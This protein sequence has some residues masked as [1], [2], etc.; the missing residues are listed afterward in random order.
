MTNNSHHSGGLRSRKVDFKKGLNVHRQDDLPDL[1]E[2]NS[3]NRSNAVIATGVEKEE[4]EEHH[5]QVALNSKHT[6]ESHASVYIPTPDATKV[7]LKN[8]QQFYK[9]EFV[10]PKTLIKF[11]SQIEDCIGAHY[12]LDERDMAW[13]EEEIW[14]NETT[15]SRKLNEDGFE[16][17]MSH[18]EML[19]KEKLTG[20]CP[21]LEEFY[22]LVQVHSPQTL[23][24]KQ[25]FDK[26]FSWWK[27]RRYV[28]RKGKAITPSLVHEE[29]LGVENDPYVCFRRREIKT[30]RKTRRCDTLSLEKLKKLRDEMKKAR[31][32]LELVCTREKLRKELLKSEIDV[33]EARI[34]V[35]K[36]KKILGIATTSQDVENSPEKA[37]RKYNKSNSHAKIKISL[38]KGDSAIWDKGSSLE[39]QPI[40]SRIK[41]R[42]LTDE[43]DGVGDFTEYPYIPQLPAHPGHNFWSLQSA[44]SH[45]DSPDDLTKIQQPL[46]GRQNLL[47]RRRV[48]RGGRIIFDRHYNR[49]ELLNLVRCE[50]YI[51]KNT[52][53]EE[54]DTFETK[55]IKKWK[56]D[57]SDEDIEDKIVEL[58]EQ[59]RFTMYR[60]FNLAPGNEAECRSL[61]NK[62]SFPEQTTIIPY[63]HEKRAQLYNQSINQSFH[64]SSL[65]NNNITKANK[66]AL[67]LSRPSLT[68]LENKD[69]DSKSDEKVSNVNTAT[70]TIKKSNKKDSSSTKK[71]D[72]MDP[73]QSALKNMLQIS[74]K[75]AAMQSQY[76]P[77]QQAPN[78][79]NTLILPNPSNNIPILP[80][81]STISPPKNG[82]YPLTGQQPIR[83]NMQFYPNARYPA[84]AQIPQQQ[85]MFSQNGIPYPQNNIFFQHQQYQQRLLHQQRMFLP[86]HQFPVVSLPQTQPSINNSSATNAANLL[87]S[88]GLTDLE[89]TS[90]VDGDEIL[91]TLAVK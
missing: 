8:F 20:E 21:S 51:T 24:L 64:I 13:L 6:G 87:P 41:K 91:S 32:I 79:A 30:M 29:A 67:A 43:K 46:I 23:E 69:T 33:F 26:V 15:D 84:G 74:Q 49:N 62:P 34:K 11:S 38:K 71:K 10:E 58:E 17:I 53:S 18:L 31:E 90:L 50:K 55:F 25:Y 65:P 75:N 14:A 86:Q 5:L 88:A 45:L 85:Q 27:T 48:G 1:D 63:N 89:E 19:A 54:E 80:S 16:D 83:P 37:R 81:T 12:N 59:A 36:M 57:C 40:E 66:K 77:I 42:R 9:T 72:I 52:D 56:F 78:G 3:L 61:M 28:E 35:R 4:E 22:E 73:R 44:T 47:I 68:A 70:E 60:A 76:A 82:Q 7:N 2:S 39:P